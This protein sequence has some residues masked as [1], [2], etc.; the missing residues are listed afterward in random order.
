MKAATSPPVPATDA[1]LVPLAPAMLVAQRTARSALTVISMIA[2]TERK[3]RIGGKSHWL[4]PLA[5]LACMIRTVSAE[6][7]G[8]FTYMVEN[9]WPHFIPAIKIINFN[10]YGSGDVVIPASINGVPV[11]SIGKGYL[12]LP[13]FNEC[14]RITSVTIPASV[15]SIESGVF[16]MCANLT[17]T[18][19]MGNCPTLG[20]QLFYGTNPSCYYL[21]GKT[22]FTAA[23]WASGL[24]PILRV[25]SLF[26][27][28]APPSIGKVGTPY[29]H[30]CVA[31][32]TPAPTFSVT[33]GAL[34]DGL[35]M[36]SAGEIY[37]TPTK[38]GIFTGTITADNGIPSDVSSFKD[39]Q[40]F[41]ID[42][43]EYRTLVVGAN[44][45]T[46]T[47]GGPYLLNATATLTA[48]GYSGYLF[49]GWTGDATG[50]VTPL[51]VL[52]DA[53]KTITAAFDPDTNDGDS[54]GLTNYQEI[55]EY[56]TNPALPDT[57]GDGA[58][59]GADAF[60]LDPAE[61][62]DTDRDGTGDNADTDDDGDG[63]SDE[64]EINIHHTN[65]K[66][67]DSDGDG[68]TD[69]AEI[70]THLTNPNVAD[71]DSDG[72]SDGAEF[73]THHTNPRVSDT[74][75]DG[76]LDGYEVETGKSPVNAADRPALQAEARTAIEFTFPA[77]VGKT[78]RIEASTDL[79]AWEI[80]ETGIAGTGGQVQRFYSTR[81][82]SKRYFRVEEEAP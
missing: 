74:D 80:V 68:L 30:Q 44:N 34:P 22:G 81:G 48:T 77:A 3:M 41:T 66:L 37:G 1:R 36:G 76:F 73:T 15:T 20:S 32:G 18:F 56:G 71:T 7:F 26:T 70:E 69:P 57:D 24:N 53:D 63:Y 52:M 19:F 42:T 14:N 38:A 59:D 2:S 6:T 54:D 17:K 29:S 39:T 23:T 46:V 33:S 65:P 43:N 9:N 16:R 64:D 55:V 40:N 13:P 75:G 5:I 50:T 8:D 10:Q 61:T 47:G 27:S 51:S 4:R 60:P 79:A 35:W 28:A 62:L 12:T 72:L 21:D 67:A 78:Y 58:K 45:G 25:P 82:Q 49:A 11:T 31:T